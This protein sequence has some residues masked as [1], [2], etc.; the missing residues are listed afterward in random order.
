MGHR[1]CREGSSLF[2]ISIHQVMQDTN[3]HEV[4]RATG[5]F[6]SYKPFQT[7]V[8]DILGAVVS[9]KVYLG[10]ASVAAHHNAD[11]CGDFLA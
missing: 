5:R 2:E 7:E 9:A 3:R 8:I 11:R 4:S 1:F 6:D 10:F